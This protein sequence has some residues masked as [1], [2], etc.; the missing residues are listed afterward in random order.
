MASSMVL[1]GVV[2]VL[3]AGVGLFARAF[4]RGLQFRDDVA[5]D[6]RARRTRERDGSA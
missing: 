5:D 3:A 2:V 6:R 1:A 4:S